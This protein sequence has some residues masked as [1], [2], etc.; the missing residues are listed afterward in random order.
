MSTADQ[1]TA[2]RK[3]LLALKKKREIVQQNIEEMRKRLAD[4]SPPA[5]KRGRRPPSKSSKSGK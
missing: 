2:L 3:K 5:A 1:L 4:V